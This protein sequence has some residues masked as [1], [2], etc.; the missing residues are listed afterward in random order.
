MLLDVDEALR[1]LGV[2]APDQALRDEA[3]AL[4]REIRQRITPRF[5]YRE[6]DVTLTPTG[7][8]LEN[9]GMCLKGSLAVR[10]LK[11]CPRAALMVCTLGTTFDAW[12]R[13]EQ[14]RNM[15]RAVLLDAC[16]SAYVEAGCEEAQREIASRHPGAFLTDRFSP[17]YGDLPLET[18]RPLLAAVDAARR[19]GVYLTDSCLMNPSKSVTAVIGLSDRPQRARI[20]GCAFCAM[21]KTCTLR[22]RGEHCAV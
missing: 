3:E 18:Q 9:A 21:N 5:T 6:F 15:A 14:A 17:G 2:R 12:L 1:Y 4:A 10:M 20:R 7:A 13:Q 22:E 16:G 8:A 11:E 19:L